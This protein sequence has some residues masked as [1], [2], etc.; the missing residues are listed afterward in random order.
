MKKPEQPCSH[1]ILFGI[2]FKSLDKLFFI[3]SMRDRGCKTHLASLDDIKE[4]IEYYSKRSH[5]NHLYIDRL[6]EYLEIID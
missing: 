1:G 5:N 2:Q 6:K 4:V 3:E